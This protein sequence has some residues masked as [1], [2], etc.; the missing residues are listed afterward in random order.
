MT[1]SFTIL[2]AATV[3]NTYSWDNG[4]PFSSTSPHVTG[5]ATTLYNFVTG[6]APYTKVVL[7]NESTD[8]FGFD[9]VQYTW[10]FGDY[11]NTAYNNVT[12]SCTNNVEHV[13]VMPGTYIITLNHYQTKT[14]SIV[15]DFG[16]PELSCLGKYDIQW[17]WD[18]LSA[19]DCRTWF[20]TECTG[21]YAKRWDDEVACLGKYCHFWS[22]TQTEI[23]GSN[24]VTWEQ[25]RTDGEFEKRWWFEPPVTVC[26]SGEDATFTDVRFVNEETAP[27]N[28]I[29]KVLEIL[30]EASMYC[31]TQPITGYSPFPAQITSRTTKCGSFPIDRIDWDPGDGSNILTVTRYNEPDNTYFTFTSAFSADISDPRNFDL[32]YTYKRKLNTYP[33]FYPSLTAYS[34]STGSTSR[35]ST[36]VGPISLSSVSNQTHLLKVRSERNNKLYMFQANNAVTFVTT[37]TGSKDLSFTPTLP[38]NQLILSQPVRQKYFGNDGLTYPNLNNKPIC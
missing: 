29:V 8:E 18:N 14:V 30:P 20:E 37:Q 21:Q 36:V 35:C 10:N 27:I 34:S 25:A 38:P 26:K 2:S 1:T 9:F 24:P 23:Q 32:V 33:V 5:V 17:Y 7:K 12:L 19:V 22:W 3:P 13:F 11:Y 16:Q 4:S 28:V 31:V 6:N 15:T